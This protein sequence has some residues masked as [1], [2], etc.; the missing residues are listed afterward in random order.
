MWEIYYIK[1]NP[2]KDLT[3]SLYQEF[4][5][6]LAMSLFRLPNMS[7]NVC[8]NTV[9]LSFRYWSYRECFVYH[10]DIK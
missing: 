5:L 3:E 8:R 10:I 7:K 2:T 9:Y 1:T 4:I 6:V